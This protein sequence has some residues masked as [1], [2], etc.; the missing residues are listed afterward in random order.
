MVSKHE[1]TCGACGKPVV[2]LPYAANPLVSISMEPKAFPTSQVADRDRWA[3]RRGTGLVSLD[4]DPN[5]PPACL[6]VHPCSSWFAHRG[7]GGGPL[8]GLPS[9]ADEDAAVA[10]VDRIVEAGKDRDRQER[11]KRDRGR[12]GDEW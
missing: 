11:I 4:G 9:S 1:G 2:R 10:A 8:A 3:W 5:P 12:Y 7:G 6:I